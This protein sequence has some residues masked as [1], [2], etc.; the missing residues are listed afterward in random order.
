MMKLFFKKILQPI[1]NR[2]RKI[3]DKFISKLL[4]NNKIRLLDIGA[5]GGIQDIWIPFEKNID[6]TLFEPHQDSFKNLNKKNYNTINKALWSEKKESQNFFQTQK[7]ECSGFFE[8]NLEYLKNFPNA[9]RFKTI[10]TTAVQ[11][12]TLDDEFSNKNFPHFIKIDTEGAELPILKG[13]SKTLDQVLGLVIE[14]YFSD[15]HKNQYKFEDVKNYL[16]NKNIKFFDFLTMIRWERHKHSFCGQPQAS[17]ILF[18]VPPETIIE[19]F[20]SN[21]IDL[22]I[23]R[24]YVSILFIFNRSDLIKVLENFLDIKTKLDLHLEEAFYLSEKKVTQV[25]FIR[26][27]ERYY[28]DNFF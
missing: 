28:F 1:K 17:D 16:E 19:K 11:T 15:F 2:N 18:L 21:K 24:I 7:P 22:N 14:C 10:K 23:L 9:K 26:K 3:R 25:S 5:A 13:G 20:N 8:P 6:L 27:I 12:T 4:N